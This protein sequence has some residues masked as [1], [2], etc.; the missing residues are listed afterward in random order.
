MELFSIS[1]LWVDAYLFSFQYLFL[2]LFFILFILQIRNR[3]ISLHSLKREF[4]GSVAQLNRA[5][6]YG[7]EG[8]RFESCRNHKETFHGNAVERHFFYV[9][10][11]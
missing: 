7:C 9:L 10:M 8:Y 5:S 11:V 3:A 6:H 1:V 4:I 2:Y